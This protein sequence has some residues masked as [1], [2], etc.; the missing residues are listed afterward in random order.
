MR[1]VAWL[2]GAFIG[3]VVAAGITH[4]LLPSADGALESTLVVVGG[5]VGATCGEAIA[6]RVQ[7]D[8]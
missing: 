6:R 4:L 7:Q 8:K 2:I 5:L 1:I 3:G